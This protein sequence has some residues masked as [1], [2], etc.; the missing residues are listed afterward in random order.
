MVKNSNYLWAVTKVTVSRESGRFE[1]ELNTE[2]TN[3][4][5]KLFGLRINEER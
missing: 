5:N 2:W 3:L 4:M 1:Y